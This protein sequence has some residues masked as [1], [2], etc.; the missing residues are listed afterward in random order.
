MGFKKEKRPLDLRS[1]GDPDIMFDTIRETVVPTT[2]GS[3]SLGPRGVFSITSTSTG[4]VGLTFDVATDFEA[5][6][7]LSLMIDSIPGT[8]T[9][10]KIRF[11]TATVAATSATAVHLSSNGAGIRLIAISTSRWLT[12]GNQGA[13]FSTST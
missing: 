1:G 6:D 4:A 12:D 5:G 13:T 10:H 7:R 8:P 11:G 9:P 2:G 3:T